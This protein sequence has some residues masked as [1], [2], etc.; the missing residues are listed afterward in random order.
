MLLESSDVTEFLSQVATLAASVVPGSSCGITMRRDREV[1]T[2][3]TSDGFAARLDEI[4][5]GHGQGPCLDALHHGEEVYA[6]DMATEQR[7]SE[8]RIH[9]LTHGVGSSL[10]MP[11]R[12]KDAQDALGALNLY[13]R[14]PRAFGREETSR[15]RDFARQASTALTLVVRRGE[16]QVLQDQLR[17]ALATRAVIDQALGIIMGQQRISSSAAFATLRE[18]SQ[19]QNR[20]LSDI[21]AQFIERF[22]GHAPEPPRPFTDPR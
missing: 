4:Q 8:Y 12:L 13:A 19:A 5:Y 9:A 2:V 20:R 7:W 3:A 17:D 16:Q 18:A 14:Y 10:S 11:L 15:A 21:A 6:E 22:T 1:F